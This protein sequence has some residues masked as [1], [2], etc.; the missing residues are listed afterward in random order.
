[1]ETLT[2]CSPS[3]TQK[4]ICIYSTNFLLCKQNISFALLKEEPHKYLSTKL[5]DEHI[6]VRIKAFSCNFR[7]KA[8]VLLFYKWCEE[9]ASSGNL[10][11][12][13]FGSEFIG[14]IVRIGDK[15][16]SFHVGDRVIPDGAY[17]DKINDSLGGLPTNHASQRLLLFHWSELIK[18]PDD[19]TD[20]IAAS[21]TIGAQTSFSM[22]RKAAVK[23]FDKVLVTA[24]TS[25]TSLAVISALNSL[26]AEVYACSSSMANIDRLKEL[27][28]KEVFKKKDFSGNTNNFPLFNVVIDPF[29]DLYFSHVIE[30]I[31]PGGRYVTCG[32]Y[33]QSHLFKK[34]NFTPPKHMFQILQHC[35]I[36][37]ISIIGNCLGTRA[38]LENAI[39]SYQRGEFNIQM[40]SVYTGREILPFLSK[41]FHIFPRF[42]KVAYKYSD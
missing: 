25:N 21:F 42:G 9:K 29:F 22:I 28:V 16:P 24:P 12:A 11:Y 15:V 13:A 8:F 3:L 7:D 27:K 10:S 32:M 36:N 41:T 33:M 2:I 5:P 14:E 31:T 1:M 18:I 4:E 26:N 19:M 23:P 40:D 34:G 17:P 37:N 30:Q 39:E 35:M 38:D 6:L 20:E